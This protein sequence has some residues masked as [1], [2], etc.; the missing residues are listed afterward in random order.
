MNADSKNRIQAISILKNCTI[1]DREQIIKAIFDVSHDPKHGDEALLLSLLDHLDCGIVAYALYYLFEFYNQKE[2]LLPLVQQFAM[3]DERDNFEMPIQ[4]QAIRLLSLQAKSD[5]KIVA[6]LT[7][8]AEDPSVNEVP[9]KNAWLSLAEIHGVEWTRRDT[10][11]MIDYPDSETSEAIRAKIRN[12][13]RSMKD[14]N[15]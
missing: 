1:H 8:I 6:L 5:P 15:Q 3:G 2:Q 11:E 12:A 9:S 4:S 13:M 10:E 7:M 14:K